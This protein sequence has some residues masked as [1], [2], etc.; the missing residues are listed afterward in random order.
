MAIRST[1]T[2]PSTG[3]SADSPS[4]KRL[5]TTTSA[6]QHARVDH[7]DRRSALGQEGARLS[8]SSEADPAA[9]TATTLGL[10]ARRAAFSSPA[11]LSAPTSHT[12]SPDG[13]GR[14]AGSSRALLAAVPGGSCARPSAIGLV[15]V[16]R[17]EA[18]SEPDPAAYY[19]EV[20][21]SGAEDYYL[22]AEEVPAGGQ[23]R[24]R[25]DRS[26]GP[27]AAED[28]RAVL[29]GDDPG[30]VSIWSGGASVLVMT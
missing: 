27:G 19:V 18:R 22:S 26:D 23:A 3:Q 12:V 20:I 21:A 13:E 24:A 5:P 9:R 4:A 30:P 28:L 14:S 16:L 10:T 8:A 7:G 15:R 25:P 17:S 2:R 29:E 11:I 6:V 1:A